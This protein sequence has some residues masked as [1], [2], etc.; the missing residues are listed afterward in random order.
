MR[1][2]RFILVLAGVVV[3]CCS[4]L[5]VQATTHN[6]VDLADGVTHAS[7]SWQATN[8]AAKQFGE[9]S[10]TV[11]IHADL[12]R[13]LLTSRLG[14][15][16]G[17]E[18]CLA[19]ISPAWKRDS[20]C[21][22]VAQ[23]HTVASVLG[24]ATFVN[25]IAGSIQKQL[26][27]LKPSADSNQLL[28]LALK[29]GIKAA[30]RID[31]PNFVAGLVFDSSTTVATPKQR[32]AFLFPAKNL[33]LIQI[34]FR[35]GTS[36]EQRVKTVTALQRV[37]SMP[38]WQISG[39][40]Y[41]LTGYEPVAKDLSHSLRNDIPVVMVLV[42]AFVLLLSILLLPSWWALPVLS[43]L[44]AVGS[45]LALFR[46]V[47][48]QATIAVVAVA[49]VLAGL[50]VNYGVQQQPSSRKRKLVLILGAM[51]MVGVAPALITDIP[52]V[53]QFVFLL[54]LGVPCA[55]CSAFLFTA[56]IDHFRFRWRLV[57]VMPAA[58]HEAYC[59]TLGRPFLVLCFQRVKRLFAVMYRCLSRYP[60]LGFA[61]VGVCAVGGWFLQI[62]QPVHVET[63]SFTAGNATA[64]QELAELEQ[65][66][67][68][69]GSV[70]V[71][72]RL[73][74]QVTSLQIQQIAAARERV[75][76]Q[77][78]P[79]P[80]TACSQAVLCLAPSIVEF[81]E[82]VLPR[83]QAELDALLQVLPR[84]LQRSF[85]SPDRR[86]LL[87]TFLISKKSQDRRFALGQLEK[88][89]RQLPGMRA[90]LVG[91]VALA[92]KTEVG[93]NR[94]LE[95][96]F[97]LVLAV[98]AIGLLLFLFQNAW[99]AVWVLFATAAVSGCSYLL[100]AFVGIPVSPLALVVAPLGLTVVAELN[101]LIA[102]ALHGRHRFS[103][104]ASNHFFLKEQVK[105]LLV[106]ALA[107]LTGFFALM[108][109]QVPIF[110]N[111]AFTGFFLLGC[112]FLL[113]PIFWG[114]ACALPVAERGG[115]KVM[116]NNQ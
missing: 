18:A 83:N 73:P 109:V 40:R 47:G 70:S 5:F 104:A 9:D 92:T 103:W 94:P 53:R 7:P 59:L 100:L 36:I 67:G 37:L 45:T 50:A 74:R 17:L 85:I 107:T 34:R 110:Q 72:L 61:A 20:L 11:V 29:Y 82:R 12:S 79:K 98:I 4:L 16:L 25:T 99:I 38:G 2:R 39:V 87:L 65:Q 77:L 27:Q 113:L 93:L 66:T 21:Q 15:L 116:E 23:L 43:A 54:L 55:V 96:G 71:L 69:G 3:A 78:G 49:P 52:V 1:F 28:A 42:S 106:V 32:F 91:T 14:R 6:Q 63:R 90:D 111:L 80:K 115:E 114:L 64:G 33:A 13:L 10:A 57:G 60:R 112:S 108:F 97:P 62:S 19:G 76:R 48:M 68:R 31:D 95:R 86:M 101:L 105:G 24:P 58:V 89:F 56:V 46:V 88:V 44:V 41:A 22:H 8:V 35:A 81:T 102:T 75:L 30:P 84:S 26:R 51:S